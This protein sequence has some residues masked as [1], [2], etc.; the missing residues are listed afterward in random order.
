MGSAT[1]AQAY[2]FVFFEWRQRGP[3]LAS[4]GRFRSSLLVLAVVTAAPLLAVAIGAAVYFFKSENTTFANAALTRNRATIQAVDA[5][6][7][8]T[9]ATLRALA[10]SAKLGR[11]DFAAFHR[12]AEGVLA[13]Q[14]Q[15]Q[16]VL[17]ETPEGSQLVNARLPWGTALL[18]RPIETRALR[19]AVTERQPAISDVTFAP[20]LNNEPGVMVRVPVPGSRKV[21]YV[22]SAVV[23]PSVFQEILESQRLPAH[24]VSGIVG[25]DGRV[26]ARVPMVPPGTLA[27]VNYREALANSAEGWYRGRTLEG[28]D[29]YTAFSR[30]ELTGW[31]IGFAIP[32]EAI[33][34]GPYRVAAVYA[35]GLLIS[36]ASALLVAY[37]LSRRIALPIVE[38]ARA[39][40]LLGTGRPRH[41][42]ASSIEE[43]STL[44]VAL[45][46]ADAAI[47]DRDRELARR[48]EKLA[49]Q[50]DELKRIDANR[51]RFLALISHELRSPL[52]PLRNGL[53]L[54]NRTNDP[55][56]MAQLLA[57]MSRQLA[58]LE[59][60]VE[61]LVDI[62]RMS[63][64]ELELRLQHVALDEVVQTS[65]E[66]V[67]AQLEDK[68]QSLVVQPGPR[69]LVNG[70]ADRLRQVVVNLLTNAS[71]YTPEGG[72]IS[73]AVVQ[74][75]SESVVSVADDG[76]GLSPEDCSRVFD[77]FV[78]IA[79]SGNGPAGSLG[80]GLTVTR[81]IVEMHQGRIEVVSAGLG[82]G[83]TFKV[84]LPVCDSVRKPESSRAT[85]VQ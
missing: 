3:V 33:V 38:F 24:W 31:S 64:G 79:P 13:T 14:P 41:E 66:A 8:A 80:I 59:R 82:H 67:R 77:L 57:M 19:V 68:R 84:Y 50:A 11:G 62:G 70:D 48:G 53:Q 75:G 7:R 42:A 28:Y 23:R 74:S 1:T 52:G 58:L 12:E 51:T 83:A 45:R 29:M 44:A 54:L 47:V 17:V 56:K 81:A 60:L 20:L 85:Q 39:A 65:V 37:W 27:G 15:W 22:L 69:L 43:V 73:V 71:R 78:R 46:N 34:G 36:V 6:L 26:I 2:P 61:D 25:T 4:A 9:V 76:V 49:Q 5:E 40:P 32:S 18:H 21:L 55:Q 72:N 30:S 10:S 35:A 16:N 63:R